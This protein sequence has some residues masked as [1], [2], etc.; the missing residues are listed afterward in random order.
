MANVPSTSHLVSLASAPRSGFSWSTPRAPTVPVLRT[1]N[2]SLQSSHHKQAEASK[3]YEVT[4]Q[5]ALYMS[6]LKVSTHAID[7][8]PCL[9]TS[10]SKY[11]RHLP[12]QIPGRP[13]YTA[14]A[15]YKRNQISRG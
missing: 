10:T 3:M 4:P 13:E 2:P 6:N 14:K 9:E 7:F 5:E 11:K 1:G 12:G 15:T 8:E